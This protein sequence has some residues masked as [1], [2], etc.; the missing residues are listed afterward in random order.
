MYTPNNINFRIV[1]SNAISQFKLDQAFDFNELVNNESD[2]DFT[3]ESREILLLNY[4][5]WFRYILKLERLFI[6]HSES[7]N[8]EG[9]TTAYMIAS[10]EDAIENIENIMISNPEF[11]GT[12][13]KDTIKKANGIYHQQIGASISNAFDNSIYT[14]FPLIVTAI[15]SALHNL[16]FMLQECEYL[17]KSKTKSHAFLSVHT[18]T[19]EAILG[20]D[21]THNAIIERAIAYRE[22]YGVESFEIKSYE[23]GIDT[24]LIALMESHG[25]TITNIKSCR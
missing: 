8:V 15:S 4:E 21:M 22:A 20:D 25:F 12:G 18:S 3:V 9:T 24:N 13:I 10:A 14:A 5:I 19:T 23:D 17:L 1:S 2:V 11:F 7:K 6:T 16:L